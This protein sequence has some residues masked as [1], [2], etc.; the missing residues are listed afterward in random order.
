MDD[1]MKLP[2]LKKYFMTHC[3]ERNREVVTVDHQFSSGSTE[4]RRAAWVI[5]CHSSEQM[6]PRR[7]DV[8]EKPGQWTHRS[9]Q[10]TDRRTSRISARPARPFSPVPV[11]AF[12]SLV[13]LPEWSVRFGFRSEARESTTEM[14]SPQ[15]AW[16]LAA[17]GSI[18]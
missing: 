7:N 15:L 1:G 2:G 12:A 4:S 5:P 10:T 17:G 9:N 8:R 18:L 13:G 11:Q 14:S 16:T 3:P 6:H